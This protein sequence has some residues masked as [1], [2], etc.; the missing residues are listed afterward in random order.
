MARTKK[1]PPNHPG[2]FLR[3][4]IMPAGGLTQDALARMLDVSGRTVNEI[5]TEKRRVSANM[6]RPASLGAFNTTPELWLGLQTDVDLWKAAIER[7]AD[8]EQVLR[9]ERK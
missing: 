1:L 7:R 8:N 3:D 9:C 4:E 6:A 2:E 5:V